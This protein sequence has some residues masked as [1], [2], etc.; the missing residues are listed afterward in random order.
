MLV[1]RPGGQTLPGTAF[2]EDQHR[3]VLGRD[4]ADLLAHL[5]NGRRLPDDVPRNISGWLRR[6]AG[7]VSRLESPLQNP[8]GSLAIQRLAEVFEGSAVLH[9]L[10]RRIGAAVGRK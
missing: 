8:D 2:A 3:A 1:D 6:T 9:R 4:P 10:D 7:Q 5:V